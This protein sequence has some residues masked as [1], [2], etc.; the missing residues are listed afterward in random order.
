MLFSRNM[1]QR[2][3]GALWL[4][5]GILQIQ[6]RMFTGDMINSVMRPML[7]GQP[8]PGRASRRPSGWGSSRG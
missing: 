8:E 7:E 5:D 3:L 1:L 2:I 4:I 6:P